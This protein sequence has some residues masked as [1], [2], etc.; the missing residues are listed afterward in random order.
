MTVRLE[1]V[2]AKHFSTK[3]VQHFEEA[4]KQIEDV[5][6]RQQAVRNLYEDRLVYESEWI[7]L[8][9][10]ILG[11]R[12]NSKEICETIA[13]VMRK[14]QLKGRTASCAPGTLCG[15]AITR[16]SLARAFATKG[17]SLN[18]ARLNIDRFKHVPVAMLRNLWRGLPIG[19]YVMWSTFSE[20]RGERPFAGIDPKTA[21]EIAA[22][23]GLF[24]PNKKRCGPFLLLEY[25][26]PRSCKPRIPRTTE[27]YSGPT[28]VYYFRPASKSDCDLGYGRT[29]VW[30]SH[31]DSSGG[32]PE[33]VH[34]PL[35][36]DTLA[37]DIEEL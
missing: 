37:A 22:R 6:L 19:Q 23:L 25:E 36:G 24:R 21:R 29:Y 16:E 27:A 18:A 15:R 33:I 2:L 3:E 14:F 30:D 35:T 31:A 1:D 13:T 12:P 4:L 20:T 11:A 17:M 8:I 26:M 7:E 5:S 34:E 32:R 9:R 10:A 28:W